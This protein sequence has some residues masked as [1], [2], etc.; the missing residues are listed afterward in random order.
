MRDMNSV[1]PIPGYII[2]WDEILTDIYDDPYSLPVDDPV[3]YDNYCV[4]PTLCC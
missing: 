3:D 4:L 2:R 1:L